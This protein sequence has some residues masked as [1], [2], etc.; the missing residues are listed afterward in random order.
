MV[1]PKRENKQEQLADK[2][3][4]YI[5]FLSNRV[6][7]KMCMCR[8]AFCQQAILVCLLHGPTVPT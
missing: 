5:L 1:G 8:D 6:S 2:M 7:M 4:L 3:H